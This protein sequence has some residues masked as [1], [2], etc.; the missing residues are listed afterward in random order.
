ML[1]ISIHRYDNGEFYPAHKGSPD[2]MG[3]GK[4]FGFNIHFGFDACSEI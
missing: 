4:G 2:L 3:K 1:Y